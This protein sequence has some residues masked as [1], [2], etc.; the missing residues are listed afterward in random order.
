MRRMRPP[1]FFLLKRWF[2]IW[3][4]F[5]RKSDYSFFFDFWEMGDT[6][7]ELLLEPADAR[8]EPILGRTVSVPANMGQK[9]TVIINQRLTICYHSIF[10]HSWS[11]WCWWLVRWGLLRFFIRFIVFWCYYRSY[12][13]SCFTFVN[14]SFWWIFSLNSKVDINQSEILI[15][16]DLLKLTWLM[17]VIS[18]IL[19]SSRWDES[20]Y[21]SSDKVADVSPELA[22]GMVILEVI[23]LAAELIWL[24]P[25][26]WFHLSMI[27]SISRAFSWFLSAFDNDFWL[28][29]SLGIGGDLFDL[30]DPDLLVEV[31]EVCTIDSSTLQGFYDLKLW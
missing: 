25:L 12:I 14:F 19:P 28:E 26:I 8:V 4:V 6:D 10:T 31:L 17:Y 29:L 1:L 9:W 23:L 24:L 18:S 30:L 2:R 13:K 27:P 5:L 11:I 20:L 15:F 22:I 21:E 16:D 7:L 3:V